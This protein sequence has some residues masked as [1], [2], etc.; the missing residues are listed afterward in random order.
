[1]VAEVEMGPWEGKEMG[2][3]W[4]MV[5]V[6]VKGRGQVKVMGREMVV[7]RVMGWEG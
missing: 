7:E 2:R 6:K 1:M 3:G 4:V 5:K